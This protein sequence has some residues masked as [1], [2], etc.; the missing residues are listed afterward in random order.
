MLGDLGNRTSINITDASGKPVTED[1]LE[2]ML[3]VLAAVMKD[4]SATTTEE[5]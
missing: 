3:P 2:Q 4:D 5:E 1:M